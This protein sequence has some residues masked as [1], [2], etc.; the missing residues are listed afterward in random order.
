VKRIARLLNKLDRAGA[1]AEDALLLLILISMIVLAGTQIFL[2]NLFDTSIFWG[3][4]ML[5]LM[6]LWL[7]VAG[8]LAASRLDKH[9]SIGVVDRFLP[10]T[11][12][13]VTRIIIDL[14]TAGLCALFAWQSA[15]FV[16]SSYEYGD[17]VMRDAPAWAAQVIM[18]I[19]FGLMALRHLVLAFTRPLGGGEKTS[20]AGGDS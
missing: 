17:T 19:G 16:Y 18:P 14:F 3:D 15:R 8:G 11:A 20:A 4:E 9:I 5:R 6:V 13:L 12:K 7:A 10:A 2:R 1:H